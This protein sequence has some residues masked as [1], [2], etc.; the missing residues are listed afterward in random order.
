MTTRTISRFPIYFFDRRR[1]CWL[2]GPCLGQTK[3]EK[4]FL[5]VPNI[6]CLDLGTPHVPRD[7]I[8]CCIRRKKNG[9]LIASNLLICRTQN[10]VF[11]NPT[12]QSF[13]VLLSFIQRGPLNWW[14]SQIYLFNVFLRNNG[15]HVEV[16]RQH[17]ILPCKALDWKELT[18]DIF[19]W[20]ETRDKFDL[21]HWSLM[22]SGYPQ[23]LLSVDP[24]NPNCFVEAPKCCSEELI[25]YNDKMM[26]YVW[27]CQHW[28]SAGNATD[29]KQ[30]VFFHCQSRLVKICRGYCHRKVAT[31]NQTMF[32]AATNS[33]H[34]MGHWAG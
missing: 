10:I 6:K 2:V 16:I 12:H 4:N 17:P 8:E 5:L 32:E 11:K 31:K 18:V 9:L 22:H 34:V 3:Q 26:K 14:I 19:L 21:K 33:C 1:P 7:R 23:I 30:T 29:R 27:N 13:G 20:H 25:Q 24:L 28:S 15:V